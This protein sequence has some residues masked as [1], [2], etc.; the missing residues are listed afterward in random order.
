MIAHLMIAMLLQL[1]LPNMEAEACGVWVSHDC[2]R[3]G[4]PNVKWPDIGDTRRIDLPVE[5][6]AL[7]TVREDGR[8]STVIPNCDDALFDDVVEAAFDTVTFDVRGN[9]NRQCP[10]I[11]ATIEYPMIFK[12]E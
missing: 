1:Q 5:C 9:C 7:I 4:Q 2:L 12:A 10:H 6:K 3:S 8:V 11:G